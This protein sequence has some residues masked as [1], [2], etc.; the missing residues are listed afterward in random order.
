MALLLTLAGISADTWSVEVDS[1]PRV[2]GRAES[3]QIR[4][5]H[6]SVSREHCRFW[7]EGGECC[8][9]D[10]GSTNGTYVNGER[11]VRAKIVEGDRVLVGKFELVLGNSDHFR[12]TVDLPQAS[13]STIVTNDPVAEERRLAAAV[14]HRLTPT[15]RIGLP[16][17]LVDVAYTPSGALAGDCFECFELQD[18]WILAL[19]DP[20]NHGTSAALTVML[21]RSELQR[22]IALTEQPG[23]CLEWINSELLAL[24]INDLYIAATVAMWFP[25]TQL[26]LFATAGQQAP[27]LI[28]DKTIH[29][30]GDVAGGYPLGVTEGEHYEERLWQLKPKDRVFFFTDGLCDAVRDTKA[31]S[32]AIQRIAE[33]LRDA[34]GESLPIQV[35]RIFQDLSTDIRDDALIVGCEVVAGS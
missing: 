19:F 20:M 24:R 26:L 31:S 10:C 9:E 21:L 3:A 1:S 33:R 14:H 8:V 22:W 28:R 23:K 16:N 7:T 35:Q 25:Q 15:H 18:R 30:L 5:D 29:H 27:F 6:R 12:D 11:I 4:L 34:G 13:D 2:L 32:P 17:L